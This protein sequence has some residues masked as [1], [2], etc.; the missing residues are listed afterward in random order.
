MKENS[1][2]IDIKALNVKENDLVKRIKNL[3]TTTFTKINPLEEQL[4]NNICKMLEIK[5]T[6]LR[7]YIFE[8]TLN[9][10]ITYL[11]DVKLENKKNLDLISAS[12]IIFSVS[13]NKI[14]K[15]LNNKAIVN[16]ISS[17]KNFNDILKEQKY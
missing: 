15:Y 6:I 12:D 9:D 2:N 8:I 11:I 3:K 14:I 13:L 1:K 16:P 7:Q 10:L 5:L 4:F 17:Y